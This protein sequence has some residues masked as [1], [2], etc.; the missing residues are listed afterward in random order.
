MHI[1][2][3]RPSCPARQT[4]SSVTNL[5]LLSLGVYPS[6]FKLRSSTGCWWRV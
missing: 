1:I 6:K 4:Y 2:D 5:G 3:N